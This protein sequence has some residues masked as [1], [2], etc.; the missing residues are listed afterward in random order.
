MGVHIAVVRLTAMVK[1]SFFPSPSP[2][3]LPSSF[4]HR[5]PKH[6]AIRHARSKLRTRFMKIF[7]PSLK[8]VP[9]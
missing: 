8:T 4:F 7:L 9:Q 6:I 2:E 5:Q 1:V 3:A